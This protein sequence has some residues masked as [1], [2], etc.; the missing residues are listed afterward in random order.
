M[1]G[2]EKAKKLSTNVFL[3]M[4]SNPESGQAY[5]FAEILQR[6]RKFFLQKFAQRYPD[7]A[8]LQKLVDER[9]TAA[10]GIAEEKSL[11]IR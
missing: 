2:E 8:A 4:R 3:Y 1:E 10:A 9:L 11:L 6:S 5:V 7:N